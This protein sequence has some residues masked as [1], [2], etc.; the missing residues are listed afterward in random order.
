MKLSET[1]RQRINDYLQ[2]V[3]AQLSGVDPD[4]RSRTIQD[5]KSRIQKELLRF[6]NRVI[7][8]TDIETVLQKFG[9]PAAVVSAASE[10]NPVNTHGAVTSNERVWL[11]VCDTLAKKADLPVKWIRVGWVLLSLL[12]PLTPFL[13]IIYVGA[14]LYL[15]FTDSHGPHDEI[16]VAPILQ[17]SA[18]IFGEIFALYVFGVF[19]L[20][21]IARVTFKLAG[22]SPALTPRWAWLE[23]EGASWFFWTLLLLIPLSI[24]AKLPVP[25]AWETT[26]RKVVYAGVALYAVLVC[27]GVASYLAGTLFFLAE[28]T[29][30]AI[31]WM[32]LF[33]N[34]P[35]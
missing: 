18:L 21:F 30:Q 6:E 2:E 17:F 27:F 23:L 4:V 35:Q 3:H 13:L 34:L 33:Q 14:Y 25:S 32:S 26:L 28:G 5:L 29:L 10:A 11:G 20:E 31:D 19:L 7:D 8:D 1:Q 15:H 24:L 12:P 22:K 9:P 16:S